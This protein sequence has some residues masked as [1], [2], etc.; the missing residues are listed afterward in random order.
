MLTYWS[1]QKLALHHSTFIFSWTQEQHASLNDYAKLTK[2]P[3]H[4][5]HTKLNLY[6]HSSLTP[7]RCTVNGV[8]KKVH[9]QV[10]K[11]APTSLLSGK[12][13]EALGLV[14]FNEQCVHQVQSTNSPLPLTKEKILQDYKDVF[15]GLGKLPGQYHIE[16]N[17]ELKQKIDEL[18]R[19]GINAKVTEPTPWTSSMVVVKK[20]NKLRVCLDPLH[21]NRAVIRNRYPIPTIE[22]IAPKLTKAKVF[23]VV[24]AKDGFLQVELDEPSSYLTTFW[25]PYGCYRWL[26]MPFGISSAPEEFQHRLDECME[27]L[28]N[29]A[30]IHHDIVYSTGDSEESST[31]STPPET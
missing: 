27:G 23:S 12:V 10:V 25:T 6:D 15:T 22:N 2:E 14:R 20:P 4:P 24:D 18:E 3:P 21:L 8:S 17:H 9:F 11:D 19:M 13:C 30:V 28:S 31:Q 16:T 29:I 26:R 7:I 1:K 5:S